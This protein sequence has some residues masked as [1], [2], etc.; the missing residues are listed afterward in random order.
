LAVGDDSLLVFS[1]SGSQYFR[2]RIEV[3]NEARRL[4]AAAS[5]Q[6][7]TDRAEELNEQAAALLAHQLQLMSVQPTFRRDVYR[8][9]GT[10]ETWSLV[11]LMPDSGAVTTRPVWCDGDIIL[12]TGEIRPGV[13]SPRVLRGVIEIE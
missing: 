7:N 11:G 6:S 1:A 5:F 10:T 2:D 9:D 12:P 8:Y 13:R 3:L 4:Q